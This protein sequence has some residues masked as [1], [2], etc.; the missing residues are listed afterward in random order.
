MR[1]CVRDNLAK[2][3]VASQAF[4]GIQRNPVGAVRAVALVA[5]GGL[6]L[7]EC[8]LLAIVMLALIPESVRTKCVLKI[9]V[10]I[11]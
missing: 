5:T 8:A 7:A 4:E 10:V 1:G 6:G 11:G 3:F 9:P 2:T